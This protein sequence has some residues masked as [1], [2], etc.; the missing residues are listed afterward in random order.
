MVAKIRINYTA[1]IDCLLT[2]QQRHHKTFIPSVLNSNPKIHSQSVNHSHSTLTSLSLSVSPL[3]LHTHLTISV[4]YP[5]VTPHSP[6]YLH[7]LPHST[8]H[9]PHYLHLLPHFHP[10][11]NSLSPS[12]TPLSLHTHLTISIRYPT[13]TPHSPHYFHLLHHCHLTLTSLSPSVTHSHA[14]L[15]SLSPSVIS[16][17][18]KTHLTISIC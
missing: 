17:S 5:I 16:L 18:L 13:L 8:P 2:A 1:V 14:T 3:S 9:S 15:K 12:V 7:L 11:L 6:H 10:T 4:S